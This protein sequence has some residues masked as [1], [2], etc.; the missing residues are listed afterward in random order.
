MTIKDVAEELKVSV[1]SVY[2]L[3]NAG[4]LSKV[5]VG[6]V[7]RIPEDTFD[8]YQHSIGYREVGR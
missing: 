1:K 7:T 8:H 5:K 6:R 3:I 2:R 4:K